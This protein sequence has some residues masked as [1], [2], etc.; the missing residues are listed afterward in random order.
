MHVCESF[1]FVAAGTLTRH[2]SP[3]SISNGIGWSNNNQTMYYNDSLP[4]KVY[5]F[6][7]DL[8]AGII[9]N[10]EILIDYAQ[11]QSLGLPDG[12]CTDVEGR[13]WI[14]SYFGCDIGINCW[15]PSTRAHV[16]SIPMPGVRNVT[17]CCFGGPN[18][19]WLFITSSSLYQDLSEYP[20]AGNV[21]V[22]KGLGTRGRPADRL[23][24]RS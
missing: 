6:D 14:A 17:S 18:Y 10:Q 11:D 5:K 19:E 1:Y 4:G 7:F 22:V 3:V 12:L 24:L 23:D 20:N 16:K 13:L 15:D 21:F 2:L 8:D 9:S